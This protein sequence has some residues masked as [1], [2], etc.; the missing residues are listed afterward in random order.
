MSLPISS[1]RL[2]EGKTRPPKL[3]TDDTLLAAMAQAGKSIPDAELRRAIDDDASHSGGL[4][5]PATRAEMIEKLLSLGY[6]ERDKRALAST[7]RGEAISDATDATL[8]T[9]ELTAR[10]EKELSDVEHGLEP[11]SDFM[12]GIESYAAT[13]VEGACSS[14]RGRKDPETGV[15]V[16][17]AG[18]GFSMWKTCYGKKLTARQAASLLAGKAVAVRGCTSKAGKRFDVTAR[19]KPDGSFETEFLD[20]PKKGGKAAG[21]GARRR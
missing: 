18:C 20:A 19:L 7:P 5:T 13:V 14:N 6:I 9:P 21:K 12:S 1:A 3:F 11:L 2:R 15:W 8:T 4:G 10:W 17:E 16:A